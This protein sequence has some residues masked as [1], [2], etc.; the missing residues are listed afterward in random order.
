MRVSKVNIDNQICWIEKSGSTHYL[1]DADEN[2]MTFSRNKELTVK[3]EKLIKFF[4]F[5]CGKNVFGLAYNYKDLVGYK[6]VYEEPL[7]FI[8]TANSTCP[9]GTTIYLPDRFERVWVEVELVIVISKICRNISV[10]EAKDYIFGYTIGSDITAQNIHSRDHHLARSKA[11]DDFAPIGPWIET[12][13]ETDNLQLVTKIN[14]V[15]YQSGNT[16]DRILNDFESVSLLSRFFTLY[17][18]DII[19]TG[20]PAN[21]MN[22]LIKPGDKVVHSIEN[23]GELHFSIGK[24]SL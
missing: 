7:L 15:I 5:F 24:E 4:N 17:P 2:N 18:G 16:K 19:L 14:D 22:S 1:L 21:A 11:I 13:L 6:D 9:H 20:T 8:K 3:D 10:K 12:D 23:L